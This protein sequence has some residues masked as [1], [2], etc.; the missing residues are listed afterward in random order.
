MRPPRA[1]EIFY[2]VRQLE[3]GG[4]VLLHEGEKITVLEVWPEAVL[5]SRQGGQVVEV[6]NMD[7]FHERFKRP[8]EA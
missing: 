3:Q 8:F 5:Y 2:T 6:T 1:G 7:T 4:K